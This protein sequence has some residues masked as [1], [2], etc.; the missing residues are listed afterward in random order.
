MSG[1]A[2]IELEFGDGQFMFRL[3]ALFIDQL[4]RKRGT[5]VT[6]PDGSTGK[7]PKPFGQIFREH[8]TGDYDPLDSIEIIKLGLTAG[9]GGVIAGEEIKLSPTEARI[10]CENVTATW[11]VEQW[12]LFA[13]T[14]LRACTYGYTPKNKEGDSEPGNE[15]PPPMGDTSTSEPQP[16]ISL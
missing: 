1:V 9:K 15:S 7:R 13:A 8:L 16:E 14:I 11:P 2:E 12:Y 6:Y 10:M 5:E 4:Q 3:P